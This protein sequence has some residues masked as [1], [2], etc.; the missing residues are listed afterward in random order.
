MSMGQGIGSRCSSTAADPCVSRCGSRLRAAAGTAVQTDRAG[1]R[2]GIPGG[3]WAPSGRASS[4]AREPSLGKPPGRRQ[5]PRLAPT[6]RQLGA[7]AAPVARA[8][9]GPATRAAP[10]GAIRAGPGEVNTAALTGSAKTDTTCGVVFTGFLQRP[11]QDTPLER[12]R[13]RTGPASRQ[14]QWS[15]G[16]WRLLEMLSAGWPAG[17]VAQFRRYS[18]AQLLAL[19]QV[20]RSSGPPKSSSASARA[21]SCSSSS[22]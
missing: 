12:L 11:E 8:A 4:L 7:P 21:S 5:R 15:P 6:P 20:A 19:S 17:L 16:R 2:N 14:P 10:G 9:P 13:H 1:A 18:G 3:N 22:A